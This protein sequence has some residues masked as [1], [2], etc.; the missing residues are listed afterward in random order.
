MNLHQRVSSHIARVNP[1]IPV[2]VMPSS[3]YTTAADGTQTPSYGT[4]INTTGQVQPLSA[5]DLKRLQG[6]NIQ[7]VTQKLYINGNFEGVFRVLG[8]GGDLVQMKGQTYLVNIVLE[9]W[10]D[11]CAVG[12]VMQVS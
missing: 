7:E 8:K 2:S 5:T 11:W 12:I 1:Y 9:R 3:G 4:T 6:L 10:P